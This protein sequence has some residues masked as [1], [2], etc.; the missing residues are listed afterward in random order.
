MGPD[1]THHRRTGLSRRRVLSSAAMITIAGVAGVQ[2]QSDDESEVEETFTDTYPEPGLANGVS[3]SGDTALYGF[4]DGNIMIYDDT[5]DGAILPLEFGRRVSHI[6]VGAEANTAA[7]G[8]MDFDAF[9]VLDL[10]EE[11]GPVFQH[12]GLW[13]L[14]MTPDGEAIASVSDTPDKS[15]SVVLVVNE[16]IE[17]ETN[18]NDAAGLDVDLTEDADNVVV[19]ADMYWDGDESVGTPG[20][21][22]YDGD[23]DEQWSQETDEAVLSANI[24]PDGELIAAGTDDGLTIVLDTDG[25]EIW[26]TDEYGGWV[27]L[28]ADGST[29]VTSEFDG[30]YAIDAETGDEQWTADIGFWAGEDVSINDDGTRV[31]AADRAN[32]EVVVVDDGDVIWEQ[33]YANRGPAI[34]EISGD[35]STWSISI[36]DNNDENGHVR[37]YQEE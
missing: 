12:P 6:Q 34:G 30:L 14:A 10:T 15:G 24:D 20:I 27:Y 7:I 18:F 8:W 13:N 3:R 26:E 2:A 37:L 36:Q 1:S 28:S 25:D 31:L 11:D 19:A 33:S 5:R 16:E 9:G 29:L 21:R 17:W 4:R 22:L 32:G 35:G 23:G